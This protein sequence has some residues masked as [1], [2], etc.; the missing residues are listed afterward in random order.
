MHRERLV[1][2]T[3]KLPIPTPVRLKDHKTPPSIEP[4]RSAH[5]RHQVGVDSDEHSRVALAAADVLK[6]PR[7]S[8]DVSL[9]LLPADETPPALRG[10]HPSGFEL[11]Q[12]HLHPCRLQLRE[13]RDLPRDRA[14]V[15][16]LAMVSDG[17]AVDGGL[18]PASPR[19]SMKVRLAEGTNVEPTQRTTRLSL[20]IEQR[21]IQ[22]QAVEPPS[23]VVYQ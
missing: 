21:V 12:R 18:R 23:E 13:V 20:R 7:A 14:R 5:R 10:G 17:R 9:L 8:G 11:A 22:I 19:Q 4:P 15:P 6:Q 3:D 16:P 1:G 2:A